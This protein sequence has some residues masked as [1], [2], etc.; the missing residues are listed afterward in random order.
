MGN[1]KS[2]STVVKKVKNADHSELTSSA[3]WIGHSL[4]V[5]ATIFGVYLA[6]QAGLKQAII[7]DDVST[8]QSNYFLRH[9]L[10]EELS[11]NVAILRTY[12]ETALSKGMSKT[13]LK[14]KNPNLNT[15][16]WETMKYSPAT[17]ETPSYF[18]SETRRFYTQVNDI[19]RKGEE[20]QYG[21]SHASKLMTETLDR[22]EKVVLPKLA[23]NSEYL[24]RQLK[25][26]DVDVDEI[27]GLNE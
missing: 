2:L 3:F 12:N 26:F 27:Q 24:V 13:M 20:K 17:L 23:K 6:A 16:V 1:E 7:F 14:M 8:K 4:M 21:P 19:I 15:Y 18:L 9:S 22:M 11:D 10:Y 25:E 5:L